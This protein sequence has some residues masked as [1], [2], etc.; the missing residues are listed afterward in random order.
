MYSSAHTSSLES[1]GQKAGV[2]QI[3]GATAPGCCPSPRSTGASELGR[4]EA[5]QALGS[6][7]LSFPSPGKEH[8]SLPS[9]RAGCGTWGEPSPL[10]WL[11]G[12]V[13]GTQ[14]CTLQSLGA[15]RP[16]QGGHHLSSLCLSDKE[17]HVCQEGRV[18][19]GGGASFP[20]GEVRSRGDHSSFHK[21]KITA[22]FKRCPPAPPPLH[23]R[24]PLLLPPCPTP[25]PKV[26]P[27]P[28]VGTGAGS[29]P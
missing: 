2:T 9:L 8:W 24:A 21:V 23:F 10:G 27:P 15:A 13:W 16:L 3:H 20:L 18:H 17:A 7:P 14:T 11:L 6:S 28:E 25:A 4:G 29:R 5:C 22:L 26:I 19:W 12:R 1:H